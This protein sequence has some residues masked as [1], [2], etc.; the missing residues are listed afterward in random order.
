M[1]A[2]VDKAKCI[3]KPQAQVHA[4][5]NP[6][7]HLARSHFRWCR[8]S[9]IGSAPEGRDIILAFAEP[10]RQPFDPISARWNRPMESRVAI[11]WWDKSLAK[12]GTGYS[13]DMT[14]YAGAPGIQVRAVYL[15]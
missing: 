9:L 3:R 5:F 6:G 13:H 15:W 11:R 7:P 1:V 12:C 10:W 4:Q 8:R 14:V 2:L